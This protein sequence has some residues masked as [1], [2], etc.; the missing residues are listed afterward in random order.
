[1]DWNKV[2]RNFLQGV[3]AGYFAPGQKVSGAN[4]AWQQM[5]ICP[6]FPGE[7]ITAGFVF[8]RYWSK[9]IQEKLM[10]S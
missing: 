9:Q 3:K 5:N 4:S 6:L 2:K 8:L 1:M 10:V 7:V